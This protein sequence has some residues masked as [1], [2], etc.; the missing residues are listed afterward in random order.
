MHI[1]FSLLVLH[2]TLKSKK[3]THTLDMSVYVVK[4][5]KLLINKREA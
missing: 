4:Q 2:R 1:L 5:D 3:K